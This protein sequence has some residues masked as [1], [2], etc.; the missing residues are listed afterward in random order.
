MAQLRAS[1]RSCAAPAYPWRQGHA[2]S[3]VAVSIIKVL[4]N[5][6]GDFQEA[7]KLDG[8]TLG[9]CGGRNNP[10]I[11]TSD[12]L[13][14]VVTLVL[15]THFILSTASQCTIKTQTLSIFYQLVLFISVCLPPLQQLIV[16]LLELSM[17]LPTSEPP[18]TSPQLPPSTSQPVAGP[19]E[20]QY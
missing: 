19:S 15:F 2:F 8:Y 7:M 9:W 11:L 4:K 17:F 12:I 5:G 20:P 14:L 18:D 16:R 6:F 1:Q 13:L 10:P 3:K